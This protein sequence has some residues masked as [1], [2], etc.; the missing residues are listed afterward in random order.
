MGEH[1]QPAITSQQLATVRDPTTHAGSGA[2]ACMTPP[3]M[4]GLVRPHV[5]DPTTHAGSGAAACA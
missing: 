5:Q 4:Q 3:L 2:A 1:V